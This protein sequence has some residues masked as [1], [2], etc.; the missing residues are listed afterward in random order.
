MANY[1][2]S[3]HLGLCIPPGLFDAN[4]LLVNQQEKL[5]SLSLITD[6][7][8]PQAGDAINGLSRL[9]QLKYLSWEGLQQ[10]REF[11]SLHDC[12]RGNCES[13]VSLSV[14]FA[15]SFVNF[16]IIES[17]YERGNTQSRRLFPRLLH[18]GLSKALLQQ[19][20]EPAISFNLGK[21]RSLSL[22]NCRN[23]LQFIKSLSQCSDSLQ[24][25]SF[26][27]CSDVLLYDCPLVGNHSLVAFL[28]SF[29]GLRHLQLRL[30]NFTGKDDLEAAISH[31]RSSLRSLV[32]HERELQDIDA[33]GL[34]RETRDRKLTWCPRL[35]RVLDLSQICALALCVCPLVLVSANTRGIRHL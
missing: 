6:G 18:L 22:R 19:R 1:G 14:S 12:I 7:S 2:H 35:F 20:L 11:E 13:L 27:F 32:H 9:K 26:E 15:V 4:G 30:S 31:H 16:D 5:E 17:L 25:Q 10:A 29:T 24:I 23:D 3:W 34:F 33:E 28:N 21:L 8:C